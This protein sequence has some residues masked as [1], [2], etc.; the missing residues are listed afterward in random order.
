VHLLTLLTC[1][2]LRDAQLFDSMLSQIDGAG[3]TGTYLIRLVNDKTT[4]ALAPPPA[5]AEASDSGGRSSPEK[6]AATNGNQAAS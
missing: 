3:D 2:L 1:R 5:P 6:P 4:E